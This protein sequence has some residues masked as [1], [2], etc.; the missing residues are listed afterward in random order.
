VRPAV[1]PQTDYFSLPNWWPSFVQ[2]GD[3]NP[4]FCAARLSACPKHSTG[5]AL[6]AILVA[7]SKEIPFWH[8]GGAKPCRDFRR[9][10]D[11]LY[12]TRRVTVTSQI[13]EEAWAGRHFD[14]ANR[15]SKV[16][17]Q[18]FQNLTGWPVQVVA[19]VSRT[20]L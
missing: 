14:Q 9:T 12:R 18:G 16:E 19:T 15:P 11:T 5:L 17:L 8:A 13:A 7:E 2:I 1:G 6:G 20:L 3:E 4:H 10:H